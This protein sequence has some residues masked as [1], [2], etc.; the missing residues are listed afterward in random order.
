MAQLK[1]MGAD[2]VVLFYNPNIYPESEYQRRLGEQIRLC[3]E[4]GVKYAVGEYSHDE[5]LSCVRGLESEPERGRRCAECFKMRV[6]F[7]ARWALENGY[8]AVASVFGVSRHKSR[9]QVDAAARRA[10]DEA[11]GG[12]AYVPMDWDE[13]LRREI[14]K[15][16][17][18][19][20]QNYCGCEFSA[21]AK[22]APMMPKT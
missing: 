1:D 20:R 7:G 12:V 9:S 14:N 13:A 17:G 3:D 8:V 21:G 10:V 11:G 5:W 16:A 6:A 18:F 4:M 2:F 15:K 19:Y 22:V